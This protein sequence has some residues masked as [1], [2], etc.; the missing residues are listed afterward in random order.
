M[1][2]MEQAIGSAALAAELRSKIV[3]VFAAK[4]AQNE[5]Y[6]PSGLGSQCWNAEFRK[7]RTVLMKTGEREEK[8]QV[9][10]RTAFS[11]WVE[12]NGI[13]PSEHVRAW[14]SSV[15]AP[16]EKNGAAT[17]HGKNDTVSLT[18]MGRKAIIATLERY[19]PSLKSD[20]NR[21]EGWI[22]D[23]G[24]GKRGQYYL[25]KIKEGCVRKWGVVSPSAPLAT[26]RTHKLAG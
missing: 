6:P 14:F 10:T 9:I 7:T 24:T 18:P 23:C 20:F 2:T 15:N 16:D 4:T 5:E 25:E 1:E 13:T 8:F 19:Y 22:K 3:P 17:D 21:M 26:V 12:R 11:A